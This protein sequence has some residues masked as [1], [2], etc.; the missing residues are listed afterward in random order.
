MTQT[1]ITKYQIIYINKASYVP[2][3]FPINLQVLTRTTI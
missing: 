2:T 3:I 1:N